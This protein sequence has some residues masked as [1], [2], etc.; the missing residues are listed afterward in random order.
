MVSK[1][2][3]RR[4]IGGVLLGF[5]IL[6]IGMELMSDA[7]KPLAD[8]PEFTN[9]LTIFSN[10]ILGVLMGALLT[11]VIQSSSA[12]VGI[13]QAL[14]ATG[15]ITYQTAI[16]IIMGQNIGTCITAILSSIGTNKNA[17]RAA[18]VHL[19]FNIIGTV[20]FLTLYYIIRATVTLPFVNNTINAA[21]IAIVHTTFNV[22]STAI[23]FPFIRQLEKLA[24]MI[25]KSD[26]NTEAT[27]LLDK[28]LLLNPS[29]AIEQCKL[30]TNKMAELAESNLLASLSL[31]KSFDQKKADLIRQNENS[32]DYYEDN[33]GTYLVK[34]SQK[35]LT[36]DD[37]REASNLLHC[38]GDF[39]RISDHAVNLLEVAEEIHIKKVEFSPAAQEEIGIL[40]DAISEI[41]HNTVQAFLQEDI[42]SAKTIEPLEQVID[43]IRY[44]LRDRHV[45]RLQSGECTITAGFIFSDYLNN[46]ERVA[47]HCS[48]IAVSLIKLP[49]DSFDT[50]E[51]LRNVKTHGEASF[52]EQYSQ[53]LKK[54]S[55]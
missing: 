12:S 1:N 48:N 45:A 26:K 8:V 17:K 28:R 5:S 15:S 23:M 53:Y 27:Q 14:S 55:V 29:V 37:S 39:E 35:S 7:V 41:L 47:D 44:V 51:Y 31:I 9:I 40:S 49:E 6:M 24:Y 19:S 11:A 3:K 42:N 52:D 10:P 32:V 54:Y 33:L 36:V 4:D 34:V 20:A 16:P 21:G 50:H 25:I 30:I 18:V 38:I 46:C 22:F 43:K 2:S 13:L